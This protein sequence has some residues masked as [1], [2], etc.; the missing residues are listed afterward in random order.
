[1]SDS[2]KTILIVDDDESVAQNLKELIEFMDTPNVITA[3]P[4]DWRQ[5]VGRCRLEAMFVGAAVSDDDLG[6]LLIDLKKF[7]PDVP[8]V[9][10]ERGA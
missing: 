1:M 3:A 10:L 6:N 2:D 7:D 4:Q 8:V 5:R 9:V